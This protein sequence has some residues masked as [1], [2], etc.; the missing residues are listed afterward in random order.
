[1][2]CRAALVAT[3]ILS[4]L[5]SP[6]AQAGVRYVNPAASGANN[7]SSWTDAHT[8]LRAA[9]DAAVAGD[10]L[11]VVA[12]V[13]VPGPT[14]AATDTFALKDG[15]ALYGGFT[16]V[17]T[18]RAQ[19]DWVAHA[20]ILSGDV[21]QDDVFGNPVWW[22]GWNIVTANSAHVVTGN[23]VGPTA[24]LDGF[25]VAQGSTGPTGTPAGSPD[26]Y[27]GGLY[28]VGASPTVRNCRF[29]RNLAAFGHGGAIYA[30]NSSPH[31]EG[32]QFVENWAHL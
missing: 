27:G 8:S 9:L 12:G 11:W 21:G 13:H 6:P 30:S 16:G 19:R 32:C 24:L 22:Q 20:T 7:G 17:E 26:M 4:A 28:L 15:V 23:G 1:M 10:E 5:V 3:L 18:Q 2:N 31:V 25:T 29:W 14:A